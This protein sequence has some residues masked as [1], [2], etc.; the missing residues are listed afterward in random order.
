MMEG[1]W[2]K[3]FNDYTIIGTV[4][5]VALHVAFVLYCVVVV[6][7]MEAAGKERKLNEGS[8]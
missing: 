5:S 4:S 2:V 3:S 6:V 1:L 7:R 8:Q